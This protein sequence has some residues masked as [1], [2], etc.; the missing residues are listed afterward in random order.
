ML[1]SAKTNS[2]SPSIGTPP[3]E[4][5]KAG[6]L[7]DIYVVGCVLVELFGEK[8]IWEELSAI[9]IMVNVVVEGKLTDDS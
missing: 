2:S 8:K 1:T 6:E 5:L 7:N 3:I 9:Q 4:Q